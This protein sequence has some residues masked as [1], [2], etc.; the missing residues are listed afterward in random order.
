MRSEPVGE[1]VLET[2]HDAIMEGGRYARTGDSRRA[3]REVERRLG[4]PP[5]TSPLEM[6]RAMDWLRQ[7]RRDKA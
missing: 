3:A 2:I 7:Q 5:R 4:I 1:D 6:V